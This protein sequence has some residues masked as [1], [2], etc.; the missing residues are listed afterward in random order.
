MQSRRRASLALFAALAV[1]T[2]WAGP[3]A[4][5]ARAGGLLSFLPNPVDFGLVELGGSATSSVTITNNSG[6][7]ATISTYDITIDAP[8]YSL[9][10]G[11]CATGAIA[12]GASCTFGLKFQPLAGSANPVPGQLRVVT[13]EGGAQYVDLTGTALDPVSGG[14]TLDF[15]DAPQGSVGSSHNAI[16]QNFGSNPVTPVSAGITGTNASDF[17]IVTDAC[18]GIAVPTATSCG[19]EISFHPTAMGAR[20]AT[21]TVVLPAP[22]AAHAYTLNGNGTAPASSVVWGTTRLA[23]PNYTW[24]DGFSLG[25]TVKSGVQ[26]LHLLYETDV[27]GGKYVSDKGPYLGIYYLHATSGS[28]WT[29]PFRLNP[30]KQNGAR[31]AIAASGKYV[32]AT[33]VSENSW[34]HYNPAKPRVLYVRV[35]TNHG[36]SN[37]WKTAKAL[38]SITGRVDYPIVSASGA[39]VHIVWTDSKTGAI[40]IATSKNYGGT[41]SIKTLGTATWIDGTEGKEGL[42]VVSVSGANV[43]VAW[44]AN[45]SGK[46][47]ARVSTNHGSTWGTA[48]TIV[49][50]SP[51]LFS[52]TCLSTRAAVAYI[53]ANGV[54]VRVRSGGTWAPARV[55][56]APSAG[57][58]YSPAVVLQSSNRVGVSWTTADTAT[59]ASLMW[60]ES[61]NNGVAFYQPQVVSDTLSPAHPIN[62]FPSVLWPSL[63][64]RIVVWNGLTPPPDYSTYRLYFRT[65]TGTPTGLATVARLSSSLAAP[66]IVGRLHLRADRTAFR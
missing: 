26:Q 35:N 6:A 48:A 41:W 49:A 30:A 65:G 45:A 8:E 36:A 13:N 15:G 16:L 2:S 23:G 3:A 56:A 37:A 53:D 51:G 46:I 57:G 50:T 27:V 11:S 25:R 55:V 5:P 1:A 62:D 47:V 14:G 60:A 34:I 21:L 32:Y 20:T 44:M 66:A 58:Q 22:F 12:D 52:A 54:N 40:R 43:V 42:P 17:V 28:S 33:W 38:T 9:N 18:S 59:T 31:R 29:K 4:G 19:V 63:S 24:N 10:G 61:P 64:T 7:S 39:Y